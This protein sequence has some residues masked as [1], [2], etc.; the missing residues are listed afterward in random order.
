MTTIQSSWRKGTHC[1]LAAVLACTSASTGALAH[2]NGPKPPKNES[3]YPSPKHRY[4][5]ESISVC[6]QGSF[7]V[8][9]MLKKTYYD[10]TK[11]LGITGA[12]F[13]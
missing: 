12:G 5:K 3:I 8:G 7:F 13:F 1:C 11:K 4:M 6:D 9:G 10:Q 2:G